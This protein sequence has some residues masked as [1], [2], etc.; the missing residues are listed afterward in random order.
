MATPVAPSGPFLPC[1][2]PDYIAEL[3]KVPNSNALTLE[4]YRS[5]WSQN[6]PVINYIFYYL[7]EKQIK[8]RAIR[9]LHAKQLSER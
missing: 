9:S 6:P 2:K 7:L 3:L 4:S 5:L 8:G 1:C